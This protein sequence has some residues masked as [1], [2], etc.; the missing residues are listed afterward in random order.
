M[1]GWLRRLLERWAEA[2]ADAA[3]E[4]RGAEDETRQQES[5]KSWI[6]NWRQNLEERDRQYGPES[7]WQDCPACGLWGWKVLPWLGKCLHCDKP[8][9]YYNRY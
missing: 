8:P 6:D 9:E 5:N 3:R 2:N 4:A 1:A 7:S